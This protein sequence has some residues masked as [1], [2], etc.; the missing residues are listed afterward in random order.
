M[1]NSCNARIERSASDCGELDR[2]T[3][4]AGPPTVARARVVLAVATSIAHDSRRARP[5]TVDVQRR[6]AME[7]SCQLYRVATA[8]TFKPAGGTIDYLPVEPLVSAG[9]S[10]RCP[11]SIEAAAS[12]VH[13]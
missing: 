12:S 9:A 6:T 13:S 11:E 8:G 10:D 1:A 4:I 7:P 3:G 5:G 2:S